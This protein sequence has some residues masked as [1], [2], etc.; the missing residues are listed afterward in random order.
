MSAAIRVG[1]V[2]KEYRLGELHGYKTLR[3]SLTGA[4][5]RNGRKRNHGSGSEDSER[6]WALKD[7]S[8]EVEAGEVLGIIGHNGAGKTTFLMVRRLCRLCSARNCPCQSQKDGERT[9]RRKA[10]EQKILVHDNRPSGNGEGR[11]R[12]L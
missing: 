5:T 12:R 6:I 11:T 2:S 8:F 3:E 1:G 10:T 9:E 4:F 7:V